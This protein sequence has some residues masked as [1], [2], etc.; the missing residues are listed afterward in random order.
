MLGFWTD[1]PVSETETV[2]GPEASPLAASRLMT[3]L[4]AG[5]GLAGLAGSGPAFEDLHDPVVR[6]WQPKA[7]RIRMCGGPGEA[8]PLG[9]SK[10]QCFWLSPPIYRTMVRLSGVELPMA[11]G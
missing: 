6:D 10:L 5:A 4:Y 7:W 1:R 3:T 11:G 9:R 8:A 2:C